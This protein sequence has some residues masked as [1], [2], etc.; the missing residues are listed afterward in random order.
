MI[1]NIKK[2]KI[3]DGTNIILQ[4][5]NG[6]NIILQYQNGNDYIDFNDNILRNIS[7]PAWN[8]DVANKNYVDIYKQTDASQLI[9]GTL[10]DLRLSNIIVTKAYLDSVLVND[11][12][13]MYL[14]F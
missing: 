7:D 2:L 1:L 10:N 6:N 13:K 9:T 12:Y 4:Y 8:Y 5:N 3:Q 11:P 14:E